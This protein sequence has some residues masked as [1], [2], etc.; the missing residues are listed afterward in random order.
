MS[1][2]ILEFVV[3]YYVIQLGRCL[4][5]SLPVLGLVLL[6][7]KTWCKKHAFLRGALWSL[8]VPVLFIGKLK[9][10]YETREGVYG[11]YWWQNLCISHR[12][13]CWLYLLGILISGGIIWHRRRQLR[14]AVRA[15]ET[16]Y[17]DGVWLRVSEESVTPFGTGLFRPQIVVPEQ[18]LR[19]YSLEE[20]RMIL[21]HEQTHIRLGHL[22]IYLWWDV[23]RVLLWPNVFLK[24]CGRYLREDMEDICDRAAIRK[25]RESAYSYGMLLLKS[26]RLLQPEQAGVSAAFT[27]AGE[28]QS[29]RRRMVQVAEYRGYRKRDVWC[30]AALALMVVMGA[31]FLIRGGSYGRYIQNDTIL[32]YSNSVGDIVLWDS[33]EL[34]EAVNWRKDII[35]VD[36]WRLCELLGDE[37]DGEEGLLIYL[38]GYSK[39]PG[40]GGGG[41]VGILEPGWMSAGGSVTVPYQSGERFIDWLLKWM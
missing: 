30:A 4:F 38:G 36:A 21:V 2:E 37:T 40:M 11:F 23:L 18:I 26:I 27:G 34:H 8:L 28:Y 12:W 39:L 13:L 33:E 16:R 1:I 7:R 41:G 35:Q 22:W 25:S 9:W 15:M 10:F 17:L 6:L 31:F 32:V 5:V 14:L 24:T 3:V 20:L 29:I 19:E